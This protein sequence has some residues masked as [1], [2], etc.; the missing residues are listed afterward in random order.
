MHQYLGRNYFITALPPRNHIAHKPTNVSPY[1]ATSTSGN[2]TQAVRHTGAQDNRRS[3]FKG[4]H[5]N[6][7]SLTAITAILHHQREQRNPI[8]SHRQPQ[9]YIGITPTFDR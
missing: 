1:E 9:E 2:Q 3:D 5:S 6:T 8:T 7:T 4:E